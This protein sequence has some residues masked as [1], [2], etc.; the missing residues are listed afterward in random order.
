MPIIGTKNLGLIK[1]IH[2]GVNPPLNTKILW[3]N[4]ANTPYTTGPAKV[5][6]YY[7]V[8]LADWYPLI[9][10]AS[11]A[12]GYTYI[13]FATDCSGSGFTMNFDASIH[14][15]WAVITSSVAI[16]NVQLRP[17][18]FTD[19]WTEFCRCDEKGKPQFVYLRFADD[20]DCEGDIF[21]DPKYEVPCADC[22]WA[23]AYQPQSQSNVISYAPNA[24]GGIDV[25]ISNASAGEVY[26]IEPKINSNSLT[27]LATYAV[28]VTSVLSQGVISLDLGNDVDSLSI[29]GGMVDN[30]STH[31]NSNP[32]NLIR[33][34]VDSTGV[35]ETISGVI[36]I[37]LGTPG[38]ASGTIGEVCWKCRKYWSIVVSDVE[39]NEEQL[40]DYICSKRL[41]LPISCDCGC[42]GTSGGTDDCCKQ[43]EAQISSLYEIIAQLES[44]VTLQIE[45]LTFN[46]QELKDYAERCC[47]SMTLQI[48]ELIK[49][50]ATL[51]TAITQMQTYY[52]TRLLALENKLEQCCEATTPGGLE[53]VVSD[54]VRDEIDKW[55]VEVYQPDKDSTLVVIETGDN[56]IKQKMNEGFA[57][58]ESNI[59]AFNEDLNET[60]AVIIEHEARITALEGRPLD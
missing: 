11:S 43:L 41:W 14:C 52:D 37:K 12:G 18:L 29:V 13:A 45:Q 5:H 2:V 38:C 27:P 51:N 22:T 8:I 33:L 60:K 53:P 59:D 44:K 40:A 35:A 25:T 39:L 28:K 20:C 57:T 21:T 3:Y 9:G 50:N 31:I 32:D 49:Q 30:F 58:V 26:F 54:I 34:R 10:A 56:Q 16:P 17:E 48:Q 4:D 36:S 7:D 47:T 23:D 1:A 19:L 55:V 46:Y 6:Y 24:D 42:G 15:Y